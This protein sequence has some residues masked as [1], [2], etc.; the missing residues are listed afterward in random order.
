[1]PRATPRRLALLLVALGFA[2]MAPRVP[3]SGRPPA[4]EAP[5][6]DLSPRRWAAAE[7]RTFSERDR[8]YLQEKPIGEAPAGSGGLVTT[9]GFASAARAGQEA[10]AQGGSAMD[11]ALTTALTQIALDAGATISYAGILSIV[12]YEAETGEVWAL[13]APF[14]VPV[15]ETAPA[16]IPR[17]KPSGRTALVP[18]F[19]PGVEAAH[20]RFGRLSWAS[21][22]GPA[23]HFAEEGFEVDELFVNQVENRRDVLLRLPGGRAVFLGEDGQLPQAGDLFRQPRLARTLRAVAEKGADEMVRGPWARALVEVVQS[24]GGRITL[25]DMAAHEVGWLRPLSVPLGE[26]TVWT[27]GPGIEGAYDFLASVAVLDAAREDLLRMGPSNRSPEALFHLIQVSRISFFLRGYPHLLGVEDAL[28]AGDVE[29]L[30]S[31]EQ[32]RKLWER[33]RSP[34]WLPTT[35]DPRP[36]RRERAGSSH[37]DAV[38][39]ADAAGN[40]VALIHSINT[41]S[42]GQTGIFVGGISIPD[43]GAFQQR[44]IAEAG[45]GRPLTNVMNPVL[46]TR[47]GRPEFAFAAIGRGLDE[48]T[49]EWL[50]RLVD[51]GMDL[52]EALAAPVFHAVRRPRGAGRGSAGAGGGGA[53]GEDR[54][55]A[56]VVTEGDFPDEILDGVRRLGQPLAVVSFNQQFGNRGF[57]TALAID[58]ATGLRRASTSR[59]F[60]GWIAVLPPVPGSPPP[61]PG[62]ASPDR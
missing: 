17:D 44:A 47:E 19:M 61:P 24:E 25:G 57:L 39:A 52:K 43:P 55:L 45:P 31:R 35:L 4:A 38:L 11:A 27:P 33:I 16:T 18:G 42:W 26:H 7:R 9:I 8:Q 59:F 5:A 13:N 34:E 53:T 36:L 20:K 56:Q 51:E 10:L 60:N 12:T 48:I 58:P 23:I 14:R 28:A 2:C 29:T 50:H 54:L 1:M 30:L 46:V 37:S 15:R 22:F 49:L 3:G 41:V 32:A 40:V 62:P 6:V 21:L